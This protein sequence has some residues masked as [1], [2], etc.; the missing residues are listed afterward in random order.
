MKTQLTRP[1]T[2]PTVLL[3]SVGW[4]AEAVRRVS[5]E[6]VT[7]RCVLVTDD[8]GPV[9]ALCF[10][11]PDI[12]PHLVVD[13]V[14][15]H[16]ERRQSRDQLAQLMAVAMPVLR[17][18]AQKFKATRI[19]FE[20]V[21]PQLQALLSAVYQPREESVSLSIGID[22][23]IH[24]VALTPEVVVASSTFDCSCGRSFPKA[25]HLTNHKRFCKGVSDG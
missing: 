24:L 6:N 21:S 3:E 19:V 12:Y 4:N 25:N 2:L 1:G 10:Q 11:E 14:V 9:G 8:E 23:A 18:Y 20:A 16:P 22:E 7:W 5:F 17:Q 15:L 13:T